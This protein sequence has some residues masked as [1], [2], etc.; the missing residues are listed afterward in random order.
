MRKRSS[1]DV[2][3]ISSS[4]FGSCPVVRA[5]SLLTKN[6]GNTSLYPFS[7]VWTSNMKLIKLRSNFAPLPIY[8]G[9]PDPESLDALLKSSRP[10]ASPNSRWSFSSN[11]YFGFSIHSRTN[12]LS[13]ESFPLGTDSCGM[14]GIRNI[15]SFR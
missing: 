5:L 3:Y 14:F 13:D 11:S 10:K 2:L 7:S 1:K 4:N 15:S 12:L 8:S 9:K 6:G